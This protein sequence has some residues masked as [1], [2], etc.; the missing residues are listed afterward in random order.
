M[1]DLKEIKA[2]SCGE[3][4]SKYGIKLNKKHGRLWGKL[5]EEENTASFS[6]NLKEN[7]WYDF[8]SSKGGS[9]IDLVAE[10]EGVSIT[11]AINILAEEY[12]IKKE[13]TFGWK[14]L[15]DSQ[16]RELGIQPERATMNFGFD[17]NKHTVEQ[18]EIWSKKYGMHIKELAFKYPKI[19][20]K[21][22]E[23]I[24]LEEINKLKNLYNE[25]LSMFHEPNTNKIT[26][27][28]LKEMSKSDA[29]LINRKVE[30][31]QKAITIPT[32]YSYLKVNF[33][34]DFHQE[35]KIISSDEKIRNK[36]INVY[37]KLFNY[38]QIEYF[39]DEQLRALYDINIILSNSYNNFI[40]ISNI[41]KAYLV[42]GNKL[43]N[44]EKNYRDMLNQGNKIDKNNN[45][46]EYKDWENEVNSIKDDIL[47]T[48][49]I[50]IKFNKV[51]EGIKEAKLISTNEQ[52]KQQLIREKPLD[53]GIEQSL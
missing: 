17:L 20:N 23:K 37:K 9:V 8:G 26:K 13:K 49:D 27:E 18:L 51:I 48:K 29:I 32:D 31:L 22:V 36:M 46:I 24:A 41:K 45:E 10:L 44:L 35:N 6:I 5:R 1:Y 50:F 12:G 53:R 19:Y 40:S 34:R 4:A 25:R 52:L 2:I 38:N 42:I 39:S 16:Y 21:M 28:F 3:V 15:T 47:K 7:L 33:E 43:D 30:L 14:P 11:E